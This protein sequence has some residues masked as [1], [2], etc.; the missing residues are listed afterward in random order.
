VNQPGI[1]ILG[2]FKHFNLVLTQRT[3]SE[4]KAVET[5]RSHTDNKTTQN[6]CTKLSQGKTSSSVVV[7]KFSPRLIRHD[8]MKVG[9]GGVDP[10]TTQSVAIPASD[11]LEET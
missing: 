2:H 10:V 1:S 11:V 5:D 3:N 4:A 6:V 7:I 8:A 9:G